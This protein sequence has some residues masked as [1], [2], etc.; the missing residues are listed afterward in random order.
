MAESLEYKWLDMGVLH[1]HT[2]GEVVVEEEEEDL[3]HVRV[4]D[5]VADIHGVQEA[6]Q[7]HDPGH[8]HD[9][10]GQDLDPTEDR[11]SLGLALAQTARAGRGLVTD[12]V[13]PAKA[14]AGKWMGTNRITVIVHVLGRVLAAGQGIDVAL[15]ELMQ[16][17]W[18]VGWVIRLQ[19]WCSNA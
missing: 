5:H 7:D 14:L 16:T 18:L 1:L 4:Q 8:D 9:L 15:G 6:G 17:S 2:D 3:T 10:E 13:N 11:Q 19:G 12:V